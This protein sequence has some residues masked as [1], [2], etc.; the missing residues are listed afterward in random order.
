[1]HSSKATSGETPAFRANHVRRT[2]G[3]VRRTVKALSVI[4]HDSSFDPEQTDVRT[5]AEIKADP[6]QR[7][8]MLTEMV[9]S[10]I[11]ELSNDNQREMGDAEANLLVQARLGMASSLFVALRCK[12][13]ETAAHC[14]RVAAICSS[15]A[16]QMGLP[17]QQ[18]PSLEIAA[19]LHDIGKISV[20]DNVLL[21]PGPLTSDEILV[22]DRHWQSGLD[23][24]RASC[25]SNDVLDTVRHASSWY[26]GSRGFDQRSGEQIPLGARMLAIADAFD[27]I[28]SDQLYRRGVSR[29]K[30]LAE[31]FR[32]SGK[33]FDPNLV[34]GF[35]ELNDTQ[36]YGHFSTTART[37]LKS[38]ETGVPLGHWKLREGQ[39]TPGSNDVVLPFETT[40]LNDMHDAV[41]FIDHNLRVVHWNP[42][43]ERLTGITAINVQQ[44][45]WVPELLNFK[46]EQG[47]P[48]AED[49]CLVIRAGRD[50]ER[51]TGPA[52]IRGRND[53][54][55]AVRL[56]AMPVRGADGSSLGT[57]VV[58]H[59]ISSEKSLTALCQ[60]LHA[61]AINDPM[62]QTA[63]R[64]EFQRVH[65]LFVAAHQQ[66]NLPCSL[67]ICDIDLFKAV[68]DTFGH[69]AGDDI[70]RSV[71][72]LL[73]NEC[74][75]GDLVARYGGE[76][77]VVLCAD[78]SNAAAAQRAEKMRRAIA[79]TPH[80]SMN[81]GK[82]TVSFG[83]TEIQ[84][85][86]TP[87]T[88]LSRADR[89]LYQ[90]K[91]RGR[92]AVVQL[93]SGM[94]SEASPEA[95]SD[96]HAEGGNQN[97]VAQTMQ[98][99][100]PRSIITEKLR[101]F[102]LD[103]R[104]TK[105]LWEDGHIQLQVGRN[106]FSLLRRRSDR[107]VPCILDIHL[108]A[109]PEDKSR[110]KHTRI[111]VTIRVRKGRDRRGANAMKQARQLLAS[112]KAYMMV[113]SEATS[114]HAPV[115]EDVQTS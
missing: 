57:V 47:N 67:I 22:M 72:R 101:G 93:G 39:P 61:Q 71:A 74:Q 112:L 34:Q 86:D 106:V 7:A 27:A 63:N 108:H 114:T 23:I 104:A 48:I 65:E 46:D 32:F 76:E 43:A 45:P 95:A 84:P 87:S 70:I 91:D 5:R 49:A 37:W 97:L 54:E 16:E 55:I 18:R 109:V 73:K 89:A 41:I 85:G 68:N 81:G 88:M 26:D 69:P 51:Q 79:M 98:S 44:R 28:T 77:F 20:A 6:Q 19:L 14:F 113:E 96:N 56:E 103:H 31:L 53:R 12:H 60:R 62:T 92:N 59:D 33:Q 100:V 102:C 9:Q 15:W 35:S 13:A 82:V 21:K 1:M 30:A 25:T 64:A 75:P 115:A 17:E 38:L 10:L 110:A 40:L 42:G 105:L 2:W 36:P 11:G 3:E 24:L 58:L 29:E 107:Q 50:G 66:R 83:V 4:F 111:D 8:V 90:A 94:P 78:C 52:V 80:A 99:F